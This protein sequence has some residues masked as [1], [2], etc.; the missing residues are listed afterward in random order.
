MINKALELAG[1]KMFTKDKVVDEVKGDR[2]GIPDMVVL[3]TDGSQSP[4]GRDPVD[5]G[6]E[7]RGR[8]IMFLV[9]GVGFQAYKPELD[10]IAGDPSNVQIIDDYEDLT[11]NK[12]I[13]ALTK[14]ICDK[15]K[16]NINVK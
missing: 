11:D 13:D 15:R 6:K 9:V 12:V 2:K 3:I 8:G 7:L 5:V 14:K 16:C 4:G 10:D 1:S